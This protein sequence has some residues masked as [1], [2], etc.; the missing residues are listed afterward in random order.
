MAD[1]RFYLALP[2]KTAAELADGLDIGGD[3]R[4]VVTGVAPASKAGADDLCYLEGARTPLERAPGI[5][6]VAPSSAHFAPHAGALI[7]SAKPRATYARIV[8]KLFQPRIHEGEAAIHPTAQLEAGVKLGPH[9]VIGQGAQIGADSVI[10][11]N[12]VIGPG[13]AVGRRANIG[14]NA[15]IGFALIGDDVRLLSGVVIGEPGFGV[16]T[17]SQGHVDVP[18][19]GRVIV[20]DRVTIGANC[21]V[22]RGMFDD[23]VIGEETKID[24]LSHIAHS[25][26]IGR[27]CVMAAFFGVAGS[28]TLGDGVVAGGRASVADH[29]KIGDGAVLA[30]GAGVLQDVPAGET[31]SGYPAK[32]LRRF[33][34]EQAWLSRRASGIRDGGSDR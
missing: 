16:A 2:P 29:R 4:R 18:H 7:L 15:T 14:A 3:T 8:P 9:V 20:Q 30:G 27:G 32:P 13:V 25:V 1:A 10:G 12:T 31:W 26:S 28:S 17:D 34:R 5:C 22:D 21:T 11:A 19:L 33:L 23:T 24:N 6:I